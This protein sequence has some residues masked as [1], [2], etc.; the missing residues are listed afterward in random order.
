MRKLFRSISCDRLN[1][2]ALTPEQAQLLREVRLTGTGAV[3]I[4]E[5]RP[6]EGPPARWRRR[7]TLPATEILMQV[8]V[9]ML[10]ALSAAKR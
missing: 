6:P 1:T 7:S 9:A 4:G 3:Y 2:E 5:D 8:G 10:E